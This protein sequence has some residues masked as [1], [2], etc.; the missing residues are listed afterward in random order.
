M[1]KT[2]SGLLKLFTHF[3]NMNVLTVDF[4][5]VFLGESCCQSINSIPKGLEFLPL[6]F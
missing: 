3:E 6:T 2:I 1:T 4:Q 5:M